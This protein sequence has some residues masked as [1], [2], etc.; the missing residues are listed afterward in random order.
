MAKFPNKNLFSPPPPPQFR[1]FSDVLEYNNKVVPC[2]HTFCNTDCYL[3]SFTFY[4]IILKL[5][6]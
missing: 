5:W 4:A 2:F 3:S 1:G 6:V